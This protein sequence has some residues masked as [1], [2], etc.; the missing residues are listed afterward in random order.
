MKLRKELL[1]PEFEENKVTQLAKLA[2][3]LDGCDSRFE[4]CAALCSQFNSLA[5]L[6]LQ[7]EDFHFSGATDADTFVRRVL[8]PRPQKLD[9][10]SYDEMLELMTR[11]CNAD[12]TEYELSYWVEFLEVQLG[13]HKLSNLIYYPKEYFGG[14]VNR[15]EM[16][17]REIL[18]EAITNKPKAILLP[19]SNGFL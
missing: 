13:N 1:P 4:D 18:D 8:T 12:G 2:E 19:S 3:R 17:P 5:D 10:I 9:D 11:V 7:I 14:D 6:D 15:D 16:T